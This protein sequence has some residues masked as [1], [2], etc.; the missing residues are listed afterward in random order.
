MVYLFMLMSLE[1]A[2]NVKCGACDNG[3]DYEAG[4]PRLDPLGA[5]FAC[6]NSKLLY[7]LPAHETCLYELLCLRFRVHQTMSAG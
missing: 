7:S 3:K 5:I 4:E 1:D 6:Q 2:G